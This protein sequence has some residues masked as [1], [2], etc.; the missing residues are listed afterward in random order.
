MMLR[1][2]LFVPG[3]SERKLAK[4][5]TT[6]ADALI[7][8]L[9]DA[10]APENIGRARG[11]VKEY[12]QARPVRER[13]QQL[14]VRVNPVQTPKALLDLAAVMPGAPD[15]IMLPKSESSTETITLAHYLSA[16]EAS[17][18]LAPEST[19]IL[20]VATETPRALFA[21]G[22]YHG[23]SSRLFG[24]TWG[25]EDL[26]TAIGASTNRSLD[27]E[28]E[29]TYKLARSLCLLAA[30]GAG[31]AAIDTLWSNFKDPEG[32]LA[33]SKA[34]RRAGFSGRIAIHPDQVDIINEAFTPDANELA[35][36]RRV[37]AAFSAAGGAG[38]IQLDGKMLDRPHLTQAHRLLE[39]AGLSTR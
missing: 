21:L 14:W 26:S 35:F 39:L 28:Y 29:F 6:R 4:G 27:G 17:G 5:E 32:L 33:D 37:I 36:A 11:M 16:F 13:Q 38:T 18:G 34:A 23:A 24:L 10:V 3:D 20:P 7:L 25:A 9:E 22:S 12:L 8:D 19:R 2:F 15:G 30:S 31:V 1:S